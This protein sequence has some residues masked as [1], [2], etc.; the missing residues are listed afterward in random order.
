MAGTDGVYG[1][2]GPRASGCGLQR[3][4]RQPCPGRIAPACLCSY[5]LPTR[6]PVHIKA[7]LLCA[8]D[9]MSGTHIGY[10]AMRLLRGVRYRDWQY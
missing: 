5:A 1:A 9:A 7:M 6:C 8:G 3:G 2:R 10:A 4:C